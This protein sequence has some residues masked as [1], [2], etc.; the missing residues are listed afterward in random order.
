[1]LAGKLQH[2]CEVVKPGRAF[3]R[4]VFELLVAVRADHH[5]IRLNASFRSESGWGDAQRERFNILQTHLGGTRWNN[6]W[7]CSMQWPGGWGGRNVT[8]KEILYPYWPGV[9]GT[10]CGSGCQW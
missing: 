2:A 6:H 3:L 1:M 9:F 10:T 5:H 8:L 4:Q 7:Y